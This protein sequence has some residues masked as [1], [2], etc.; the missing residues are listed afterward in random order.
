MEIISDKVL[1][2]GEGKAFTTVISKEVVIYATDSEDA[3][4][5][6]EVYMDAINIENEDFDVEINDDS[7][8]T[9]QR[10]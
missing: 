5:E 7:L 9:S 3:K 10:K 6:A 4:R 2:G 1:A 8:V